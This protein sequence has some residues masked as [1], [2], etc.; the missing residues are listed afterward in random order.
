MNNNVIPFRKSNRFTVYRGQT[1]S[2]GEVLKQEKVGFAFMKPGAK[3]FRLK[4][5]LMAGVSYFVCPEDNDPSKYTVIALEEYRTPTGETRTSWNRI[6]H[7]E[8]A[9]SFLRLKIHLLAEDVYLCLFPENSRPHEQRAPAHSKEV[10]N[11]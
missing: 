3:R 11:A 9:G 8:V 4:L 2:N 10:S 5:W 7:G 1:V 6:G